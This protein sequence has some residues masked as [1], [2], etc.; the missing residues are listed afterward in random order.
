MDR[1]IKL[2]RRVSMYKQGERGKMQW[3]HTYD[4]LVKYKQIHGAKRR[5]NLTT[6]Y[7]L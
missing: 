4:G 5:F 3:K 7:P 1:K 2:K 6:I